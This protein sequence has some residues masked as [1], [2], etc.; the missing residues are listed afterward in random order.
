MVVE[1]V[2]GGVELSQAGGM[3]EK[4]YDEQQR[5]FSVVVVVGGG[6]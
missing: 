2:F 5:W 6:G 4:G 3:S 1:H